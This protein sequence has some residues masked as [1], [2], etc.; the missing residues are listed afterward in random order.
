M[1]DSVQCSR[2]KFGILQIILIDD[3]FQKSS[4]TVTSENTIFQR[5]FRAAS[6]NSFAARLCSE[7]TLAARLRIEHDAT[8]A[9]KLNEK[10]SRATEQ[11]MIFFTSWY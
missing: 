4:Y 3:M 2:A 11:A 6:L 5:C 10:A 7:S 9:G 8:T 1:A